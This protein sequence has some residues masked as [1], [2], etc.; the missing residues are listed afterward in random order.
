MKRTATVTRLF[1]GR[2]AGEMQNVV[3][4]ALQYTLLAFF[5]VGWTVCMELMIAKELPM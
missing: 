1:M 5:F 4:F 2:G 3:F